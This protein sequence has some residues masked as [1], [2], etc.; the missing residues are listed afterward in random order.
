MLAAM[1]GLIVMVVAAFAGNLLCFDG[2]GLGLHDSGFQSHQP[3][4]VSLLL[5]L[6]IPLL[7]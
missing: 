3:L 6:F 4:G 7:R 5:A 2:S 1:M